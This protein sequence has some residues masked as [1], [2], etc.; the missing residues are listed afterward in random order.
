MTASESSAI[1]SDAATIDFRVLYTLTQKNQRL[2]L[3]FQT[4]K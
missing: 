4:L 3:S 2:S 1:M